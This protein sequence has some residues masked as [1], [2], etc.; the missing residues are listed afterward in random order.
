MC[1]DLTVGL[2]ALA[3]AVSLYALLLNKALQGRTL[4]RFDIA[5]PTGL[6]AYLKARIPGLGLSIRASVPPRGRIE[7]LSRSWTR[8]YG[9]THEIQGAV[10]KQA[11]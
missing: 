3:L 4:A 10:R 1:T 9:E 7:G 6:P 5:K 8:R 11:D 2:E